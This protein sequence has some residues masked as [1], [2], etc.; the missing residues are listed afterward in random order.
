MGEMAT[1]CRDHT[2]MIMKRL[3]MIELQN[4]DV[5]LHMYFMV[6]KSIRYVILR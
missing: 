5:A 2:E 3:K 4:S 1:N 6:V